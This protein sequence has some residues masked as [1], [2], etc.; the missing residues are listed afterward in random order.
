MFCFDIVSTVSLIKR[1]H[2]L[3]LITTLIKVKPIP[4]QKTNQTRSSKEYLTIS[5]HLNCIDLHYRCVDTIS[6][7]NCVKAARWNRLCQLMKKRTQPPAISQIDG[8]RLEDEAKSD[9]H[10]RELQLSRKLVMTA[11]STASMHKELMNA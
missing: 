11:T 2:S 10:N 1:E 5:R 8:C 7:I 6:K 9:G 3:P 4:V